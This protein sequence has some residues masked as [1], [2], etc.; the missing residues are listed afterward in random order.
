MFICVSESLKKGLI[1]YK[2]QKKKLITITP[3]VDIFKFKKQM[4]SDYFDKYLPSKE[5][6]KVLFVGRLDMQKVFPIY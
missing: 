3:G 2:I 4:S 1:Q 5:Y 6:K